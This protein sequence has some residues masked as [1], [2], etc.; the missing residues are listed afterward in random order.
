MR[1][2]VEDV[3]NNNKEAVDI[4]TSMVSQTEDGSYTIQQNGDYYELVSV[5]PTERH[6][7]YEEWVVHFIRERYTQDDEYAIL[8]K[9]LA[10]LDP[11]EFDE[12]N[13]FCED[14]KVRAK[15]VTNA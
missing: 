3:R 11:E 5:I 10:G 1:V 14:C 6:H 9:K 2:L 8:R 15:E 4:Y 7:T 12:Y 13:A